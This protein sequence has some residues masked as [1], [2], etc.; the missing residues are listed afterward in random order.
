MEILN[1]YK[2]FFFVLI[3]SFFL[4][5][6][7]KSNLHAG[8][9]NGDLNISCKALEYFIQYIKNPG[10]KK[11]PRSSPMKFSISLDGKN[12]WYYH[13]PAATSTQFRQ[14]TK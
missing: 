1:I 3:I 7:N 4:I 2:K 11:F 10:G 12:A 5:L 14:E 13:C 8:Y 9:G 6:F